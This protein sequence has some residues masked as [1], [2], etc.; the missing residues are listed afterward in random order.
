MAAKFLD[1]SE[2]K[3][4]AS[5]TNA[6]KALDKATTRTDGSEVDS[7]A[8]RAFVVAL[9]NGRFVPAVLPNSARK[10]THR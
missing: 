5:Y 2:L 8:Y 6:Q 7:K 1:L 9:P 4:Y 10:T 3:G